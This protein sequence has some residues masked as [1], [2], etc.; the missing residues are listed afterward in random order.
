MNIFV[1]GIFFFLLSLLVSWVFKSKVSKYSAIP[2][3]SGLS[4]AEV[5]RKMLDEHEIYDVKIISTEGQLTDHYNPADKSINLSADVYNGR[6]I[7]SAAVA[8]HETGHAIQHSRA[9]SFLTMRSKIVPVVQ[10]T[11]NY[12]QWVILG[13]IIFFQTFPYLLMVGI[14]MFALITLFSFITLPVEFDASKRA[15]AWIES[16]NVVSSTEHDGAKD[17]LNW[18]AMTYV[19]AAL[20]SLATLLYY[21]SMFMG[22]RE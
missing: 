12:V 19:I 8:A 22:R 20:S 15:L 17:A 21:I 11:S 7:I 16:R 10:I 5:A 6:S 1:I 9:Y 3:R 2:L 13:G 18:A 14:A 4:G